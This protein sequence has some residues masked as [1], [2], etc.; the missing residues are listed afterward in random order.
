[1]EEVPAPPWT[2]STAENSPLVDSVT[3]DEEEVHP[4]AS[5]NATDAALPKAQDDLRPRPS[6][7]SEEAPDRAE[8]DDEP[9]KSRSRRPQ[10]LAA[11]L[12]I[13]VVVAASLWLTGAL[14]SSP[15]SAPP[16]EPRVVTVQNKVAEGVDGL[17]EDHTSAYLSSALL[18]DCADEANHCEVSNTSMSSGAA[19]IANCVSYSPFK[20]YNY[21]RSEL[22]ALANPD[23]ASSNRWYRAVRNGHVGYISEIYIVSHDRGGLGLPD[24]GVAPS[25]AAPR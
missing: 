11:I 8:A 15:S 16:G 2:P 19:I 1:M 21:N 12:L 13:V 4:S 17:V 25:S 14:G 6:P 20:M 3:Q 5:P 10:I 18:P 23:A 7:R 22:L 9:P 24:C